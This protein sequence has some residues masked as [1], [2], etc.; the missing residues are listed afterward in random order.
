MLGN[1]QEY[2]VTTASG[3]QSCALEPLQADFPSGSEFLYLLAM[4]LMPTYVQW[5]V[6]VYLQ[7]KGVSIGLPIAPILSDLL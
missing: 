4:Y 7:K 5:N 1:A 2:F 6:G 3:W